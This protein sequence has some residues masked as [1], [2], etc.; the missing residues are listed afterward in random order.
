MASV[1][2]VAEEVLQTGGHTYSI[3]L[4][5]LVYYAQAYHLVHRGQP[6]FTERITARAN[7]P[8]VPALY[9]IYR[10]AFDVETVGGDRSKLTPEEADSVAMVLQIYGR[11]TAEW[12]VK[13]T[14]M[15]PP[16]LEAREGLL[17]G[18]KASPDVDLATMKRYYAR[19]FKTQATISENTSR[20]FTT[21]E[22][23]ERYKCSS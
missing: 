15:E 1:R 10:G 22:L 21:D 9:R 18:A 4:Q 3:R 17:P 2:D 23:K 6:L 16:W 8:V 12:L 14:R 20:G 11:H 13:Q 7:G 5:T 19:V